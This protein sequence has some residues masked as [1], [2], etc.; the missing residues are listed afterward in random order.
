LR[1]S[2]GRQVKTLGR[3]LHRHQSTRKSTPSGK[4]TVR[5][6]ARHGLDL[7]PGAVAVFWPDS[8]T[9]VCRGHLVDPVHLRVMQQLREDREQATV[10]V[11]GSDIA[12]RLRRVC[13]HCTLV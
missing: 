8:Q 11:G 9:V 10:V 12:R 6:L 2:I 4:I 3:L 5:E 7:H 13:V 1:S